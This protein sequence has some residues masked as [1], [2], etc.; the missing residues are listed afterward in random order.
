MTL[1]TYQVFKTI[2]DVGSFHK[3]ADILG[4][5]P[6]AISHAISSMENELGF[7]V[8]TRSKA[9]VSLTNYGEQLLPYVNA[10][11]NCDESLKQEIAE[12]NGLKQ[13]KV[14]IGV[15]SSVCTSWLP[16]ILH[17]FKKKYTEIDI[18]VFQGTY[19]DVVYWIK[20]GVVDLGFL[21]V[22]SAKDIPIEPLYR[23]ELLCVLPSG[24][25]ANKSTNYIDIEEMKQNKFIIAVYKR[26]LMDA[27][28][29][30]KELVSKF[31]DV[32]SS[33]QKE[34]DTLRFEHNMIAKKHPRWLSKISIEKPNDF[35]QEL[36]RLDIEPFW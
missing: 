10:V 34:L 1:L 8:L 14:K 12:L 3:A 28:E 31:I 19:D 11:L 17:S 35:L 32:V 16:E 25:K 7:S 36:K 13:G 5:T 15:F 29:Q 6:S 26:L 20:N 2:A 18:E 27:E 23:D 21:S 4:L 24:T 33:M 22:S 9:G 30:R